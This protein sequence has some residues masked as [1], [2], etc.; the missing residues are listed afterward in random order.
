MQ[1]QHGHTDI[2]R[3]GQIFICRPQGGFNLEGAVEYEQT[4]A[5]EVLKVAD[6]PWGILEV[7]TDFGAGSDEVMTRFAN[8]F[9]WCSQ[10]NCR[11]LAVV[12]QS[13]LISSV[14]KR[15][16]E[17]VPLDMEWFKNESSAMS[18]LQLKLSSY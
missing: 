13:L 6:K 8:Q 9:T 15:Y 4:F 11:Y 17:N 14:I 1:N 7:L 2:A 3:E 10:N 16:F 12:N 18:W 5:Q